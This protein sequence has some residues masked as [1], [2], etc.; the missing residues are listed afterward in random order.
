MKMKKYL[1][2]MLGVLLTL[3][4]QSCFV[5]PDYNEEVAF[6]MRPWFFGDNDVSE[7]PATDLTFYALTSTPVT[8]NMLPVKYSLKYEDLQSDNNTLL[9]FTADVYIQIQ[10]GKTP[11]LLRNYGENW[12]ET[13]MRPF[14]DKKIRNYVSMYNS[15]DLMSNK[16]VLDSLDRGIQND[17][18][19]YVAQLNKEKEFPIII[20]NVIM[21]RGLPN[22]EQ[23][24]EMNKTA[25]AIQ[26]AETQR[27]TTEMEV[28]RK[29]AEEARAMADRAYMDKMNL[30][31]SQFIQLRAWDVI[32]KKQGANIDV[33]VG[34]GETQEMWNIKR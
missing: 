9:D 32:E 18:E 22:D 4:L 10:K 25:A 14:I 19:E 2:I 26:A 24:K 33:L 16:D 29:E 20:K 13:F 23:K 1:S 12:Y 8:F 27:R 11:E 3:S 30:N 21:G 6:K 31:A 5:N 28:A 34:A 15:F 7:T 17:L